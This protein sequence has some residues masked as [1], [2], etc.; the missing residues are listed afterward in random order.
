MTVP[1]LKLPT[2]PF[3][4]DAHVRHTSLHI[5]R[6]PLTSPSSSTYASTSPV[7][8]P[9]S[10]S[11]SRKGSYVPVAPDDRILQHTEP[12]PEQE[13]EELQRDLEAFEIEPEGY[14]A[15][16]ARYEGPFQPPEGKEMVGIVAS[17]VGVL[18][19]AVAAGFTTVYDWVL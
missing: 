15:E 2:N 4:S 13:D 17:I 6:S 9:D 1:T 11:H 12:V 7:Y 16:A 10:Y 14:R 19:L 3:T 18:I 8:R 5:P